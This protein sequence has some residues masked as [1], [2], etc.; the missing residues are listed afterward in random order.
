MLPLLVVAALATYR[1]V[2][3]AIYDTIFDRP[4][5]A[6]Y[7]WLSNRGTPRADWMLDM[8]T[9][10]WCLGVWMSAAVTAALAVFTTNST[11]IVAW[12]AFWF[13]TSGAQSLLHLIEDAL[14][15]AATDHETEAN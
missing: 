15:A 10:Q 7:M 3:L 14:T 2:R 9:C 4:R 11:A 5:N 13:A 12:I 8:V 1:L 6:T